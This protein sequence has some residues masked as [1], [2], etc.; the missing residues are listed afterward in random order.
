M[1]TFK[2]DRGTA[3]FRVQQMMDAQDMYIIRFFETKE[4]TVC[5]AVPRANLAPPP[6]V[7]PKPARKRVRLTV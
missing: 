1:E 6:K 3:M 4:N 7:E 2:F 5:L